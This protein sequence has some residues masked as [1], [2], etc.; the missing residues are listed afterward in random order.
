MAQVAL[1]VEAAGTLERQHPGPPVNRHISLPV[2][3]LRHPCLPRFP[4]R[5]LPLWDR[6]HQVYGT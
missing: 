4:W 5:I 3:V 2:F 1:F 6:F